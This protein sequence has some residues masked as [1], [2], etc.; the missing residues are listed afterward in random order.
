MADV[1]ICG[2]ACKRPTIYGLLSTVVIWKVFQGFETSHIADLIQN[3]KNHF[4]LSVRN[5]KA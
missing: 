2:W 3:T 5:P 1:Q 4:E